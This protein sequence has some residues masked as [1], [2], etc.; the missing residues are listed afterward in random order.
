MNITITVQLVPVRMKSLPE[1]GSAEVIGKV[2]ETPFTKSVVW[3]AN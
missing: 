1:I 2:K 3:M